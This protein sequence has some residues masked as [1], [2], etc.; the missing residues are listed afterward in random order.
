MIARLG[1][2]NNGPGFAPRTWEGSTMRRCLVLLT[3]L[4]LAGLAAAAQ[5]AKPAR[6]DLFNG[7]DFD[8]WKLFL[9]DAGADPAKTWSVR[10]G[11][12]H[13]TGNPAGYMRT[14]TPYENYRLRLQWR[15]PEGAGNN[16][17]LLHIQ[18]KDEVWPKSLE[19]QLHSGDAGDF[20]VIGGVETREHAAGG[21]RVNGR[22]TIKLAPSSEK[23]LGEWNQYEIVCKGDTVKSYVN[24]VLQNEANDCTVSKGYIGLQ[25]EGTPVE[26]REIFIEPLEE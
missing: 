24:G 7:K 23:P 25:S 16:G 22:R 14:T 15:F 17:V 19:S 26:F 21:A 1:K 6:I 4:V 10:D 20:W 8:G 18:D 2:C 9:P 13:C 11:V 5:D 3:A 12:I